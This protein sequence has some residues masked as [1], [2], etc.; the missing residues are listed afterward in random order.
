MIVFD[1]GTLE[2][3]GISSVHDE[4]PSKERRQNEIINLVIADRF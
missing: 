4:K 2:A 1:S 3:N